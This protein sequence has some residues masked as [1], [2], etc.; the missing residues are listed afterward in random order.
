MAPQPE[1]P[2]P[3]VCSDEMYAL[4]GELIREVWNDPRTVRDADERLMLGY[5]HDLIRARVVETGLADF[6]QGY[7][8]PIYG[9]LSAG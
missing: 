7:H 8:D 1:L 3:H 6:S 2:A 9:P 5:P 4:F